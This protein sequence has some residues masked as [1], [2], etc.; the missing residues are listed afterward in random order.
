MTEENPIPKFYLATQKV[1]EI[2]AGDVELF[3]GDT[4]NAYYNVF[5]GDAYDKSVRFE[6]MDE[7]IVTVSKGKTTVYVY[8]KNG[9]TKEVQVTVQ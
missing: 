1:E 2:V 4:L 7:T 9:L 8:A 3:I 6:S 5:P